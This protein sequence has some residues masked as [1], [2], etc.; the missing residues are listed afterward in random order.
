[1]D[2]LEVTFTSE[3]LRKLANAVGGEMDDNEDRRG[4]LRGQRADQP[5]KRLETTG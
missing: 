5:D 3:N 1:M 4:D 2:G